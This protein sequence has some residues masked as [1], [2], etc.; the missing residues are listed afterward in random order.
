MEYLGIFIFEQFEDKIHAWIEIL[1]RI[2]LV[3]D[4]QYLRRTIYASSGV[5]RTNNA[6][7]RLQ[8]ISIDGDSPL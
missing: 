7:E 8:T 1:A 5:I 6:S 3:M 2:L 4:A